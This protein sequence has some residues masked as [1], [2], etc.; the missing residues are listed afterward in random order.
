MDS[1]FTKLKPRKSEEQYLGL[2][3][4]VLRAEVGDVFHIVFKNNA[5]IPYSMHPHGVFYERPSEGAVYDKDNGTN[6]DD[7]NAVP[8]GGR[9]T[10][11]WE[12]P[13]RAGPGSKDGSSVV[14]FYHSHVNEPKDV[15]A[16]LVG[17]MIITAKGKAKPDG[18]PKDVDR[19]FISLY[20]N[21]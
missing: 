7:G 11:T 4:P 17:A 3:G 18:S 20:N 2:L 9:F 16:G 8:P 1:T 14:W 6:T 10:Y 13:E 19:E 5:T 12:V 15:N 21:I